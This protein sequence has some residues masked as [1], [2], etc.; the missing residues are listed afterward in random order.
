MMMRQM[1][2]AVLAALAGAGGLVNAETF[3][4]RFGEPEEVAVPLREVSVQSTVVGEEAGEPVVYFTTAGDPAIFHAVGLAPYRLKGAYP[5]PGASRSWTHTI[6]PDGKVY[7]GGVGAKGGSAR[8]YRYDP[9]AQAVEDLGV[10][11]AGDN[12][13]WALT[14]DPEGNIYG[15]TW[16]GSHVFRF[17]P[18]TGEFRDYGALDPNE[19][20]VRTVAWHDGFVYAGTGTKN[21]RVWKLDPETGEAERIAIPRRPEYAQYYDQ[22]TT[23]YHIDVVGDVL[24]M[25][26]SLNERYMLAYDLKKQEWWDEVYDDVRGGLMGV[27]SPEEDI[28][29]VFTRTGIEAIDMETHEARPVRAGGG[30]FR[31]AG[32]VTVPDLEVEGEVLATVSFAGNVELMQPETGW[33]KVLPSLAETQ[34]NPIQALE[35]GP[36]NLFYVSGYMG[37]KGGQ[38]NPENGESRTFGIGQAEGIGS[39][40]TKLY[41]GVYPHA[42]IMMLDTAGRLEPTRVFHVGHDQD[43]PFR[44]TSGDGKLFIGTI[45][46]YGQLGGAVSVYDPEADEENRVK[47]FPD[48]I[49]DQSIVGLAWHE[50]RLYGSTSIHGGLGA[51]LAAE[52]ARVFVWDLER[53]EVVLSREL[54]IPGSGTHQMISGISAGPDGLI[55]GAVNGTVFA[56]D[57]ETLEVVRHRVIYPDVTRHGRWRPVYFRWGED[58]LLYCNPGDRITAIDPETLEFR[59]SGLRSGLMTLGPDGDVYFVKGPQLFR[60]PVERNGRN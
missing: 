59:G 57:P 17:D 19:D 32:W 27:A 13:I 9:E 49:R 8:L 4:V 24:F 48:I 22:M 3:P 18:E 44:I 25:F 12:F 43:R 51:D 30:T 47:V 14:S 37:S 5:L 1:V 42:E 58:G 23:V 45:P 52:K 7:I 55:W 41:W 11:I 33:K 40:G 36:D 34:A 10:A 46:G 2:L 35:L 50:G 56:L 20:R 53:E 39:L 29:Y 15:G 54:E 26:F 28:Y 38:V 31:G 16:E 6:A 21:G 60:L